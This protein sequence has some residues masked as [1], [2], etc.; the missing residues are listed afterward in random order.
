[1]QPQEEKKKV[2]KVTFRAYDRELVEYFPVEAEKEL[3]L[4][5]LK[6]ICNTFILIKIEEIYEQ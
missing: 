5:K 1:M 4:R 3:I 6:L 2:T